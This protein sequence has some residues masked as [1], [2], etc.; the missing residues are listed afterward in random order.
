MEPWKKYGSSNQG[1]DSGGP[2]QKY[3]PLPDA[4]DPAQPLNL[5]GMVIPPPPPHPR[6]A[7]YRSA[8]YEAQAVSPRAIGKE[9]LGSAAK[10]TINHGLH[11][12]K[13]EEN[14]KQQGE[15]RW[16]T[17][18]DQGMQGMTGNFSDE[19]MDWLGTAYAKNAPAWMGGRPDLMRDV[20]ANELF[21]EARGMSQDRLDRQMQQHPVLSVAS[22]IAGGALTSGAGASTKAGQ[23]LLSRVGAGN[24]AA[25]A[26]KGAVTGAALGG[27]YG[28]GGATEGERLDGAADGALWGAAL[29]GAFPVAGAGLRRLNTKTIVPGADEVRKAASGLYKQADD[30]GGVLKPEFTNKFIDSV[31][32]LRPQTE[33]GRAVGGDSLFTQ[34]SSRLSTIRNK[35]MTL[36]AAQ[37]VDELLGDAIDS[38]IRDGKLTKEGKRLFDIQS[39]L[40]N[41]IESADE[42]LID[43]GREGFA[44]L[45][46]ARKMWGVSRRMGDIE[47]IIQNADTYPVPATAIKTGFRNIVKNPNRLRGYSPAEVRAMEKAARTGITTDLLNVMGSRLGAIGAGAGGFAVGGPL[48]GAVAALGTHVTSSAARAAATGI[49]RG[50]A[51]KALRTVAERSGMVKQQQRIPFSEIMKLPPAEARRYLQRNPDNH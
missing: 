8:Q 37:E 2:W 7:E 38:L 23:A 51:N 11:G 29:G 25:R 36:Q 18:L 1:N 27:V 28:A 48:A 31:D 5:G 35:P 13:S 20:S 42:K 19:V 40:R 41:M 33:I 49:Q 30:L 4:P 22:N 14:K 26:A 50:K 15:S 12:Q 43:G 46:E 32:A 24:L 21:D 16:R 47:R 9:M 45:K 6:D 44:A 10:S 39:N 3:S 34:L 17:A